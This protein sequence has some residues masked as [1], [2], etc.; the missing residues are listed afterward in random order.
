[1]VS[2]FLSTDGI[3]PTDFGSLGYLIVGL[4]PIIKKLPRSTNHKDNLGVNE[5]KP[6]YKSWEQSFIKVRI[7]NLIIQLISNNRYRVDKQ[8]VEVAYHTCDSMVVPLHINTDKN[9]SIV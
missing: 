9:K 7:S 6:K 2:L 8:E 4:G 1:M 3:P 5:R